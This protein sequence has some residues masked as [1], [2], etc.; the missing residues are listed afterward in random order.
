MNASQDRETRILIIE[1]VASDAALAVRELRKAEIPFSS[2]HVETRESFLTQLKDFAPDLSRS[3]SV[4]DP[5]PGDR[6]VTV[7]RDS[8]AHSSSPPFRRLRRQPLYSSLWDRT[9]QF[10]SP[11]VGDSG[12]QDR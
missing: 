9:S 6:K 1:D 7:D 12:I 8:H 11:W 5:G 4:N 2:S 3:R 10:L